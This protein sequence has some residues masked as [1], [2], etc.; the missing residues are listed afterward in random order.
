MNDWSIYIV[1]CADGTLYTGATNDVVRRIAQHNRGE[2]ARYTRSRRP[3][4]LIYE[5]ACRNRSEAQAREY[6]I[7][8]LSRAAKLA[9]SGIR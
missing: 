6:E 4:T 7:K 9:L 3:V 8:Q 2:G 1:R 5:E